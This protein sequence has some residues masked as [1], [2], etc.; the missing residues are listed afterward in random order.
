MQII[1]GRV[2]VA[3]GHDENIVLRARIHIDQIADLAID[4]V[5]RWIDDDIHVDVRKAG[6]Q[7][8]DDMQR[9]VCR[10]FQ[11]ENNLK[12]RIVLAAERSQSLLEHRLITV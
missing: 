8:P 5:L 4:P 10:I 7:P 1:V 12:H 6:S 2:D 11:A 3:I 9:R